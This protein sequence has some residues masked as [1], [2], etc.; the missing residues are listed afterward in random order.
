MLANRNVNVYI[1][2]SEES[3]W[4]DRLGSN[5]GYVKV[6]YMDLGGNLVNGVKTFYKDA[7][8]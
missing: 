4:K 2:G 3:V 5:V 7:N 6:M 1:Q 8:A